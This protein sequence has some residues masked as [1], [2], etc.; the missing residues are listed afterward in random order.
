MKYLNYIVAI[1]F[2]SSENNTRVVCSDSFL[3]FKSILAISSD[4]RN[5]KL[6]E[7]LLQCTKEQL[8]GHW[9]IFLAIHPSDLANG[10]CL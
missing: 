1:S 7:G 3:E 4:H 6:N 9:H 2:Q 10:L 5:T 8:H